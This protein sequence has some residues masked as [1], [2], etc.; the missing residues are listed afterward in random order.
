MSD[1]QKK[2]EEL[3]ELQEEYKKVEQI[4][5]QLI[6]EMIRVGGVVDYLAEKEKEV[7]I[8]KNNK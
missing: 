5:S 4:K 7:K 8:D 1:L 2:Q 6:Q 3:K